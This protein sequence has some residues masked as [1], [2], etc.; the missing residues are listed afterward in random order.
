LINFKKKKFAIII[1]AFNEEKNIFKLTN[2]LL[3]LFNNAII[4]IIDDSPKSLKKFFK[5]KKIIY[6]NRKNKRGRGSAV[7]YGLRQ[8]LKLKNIKLFVEMDADFSHRPNELNKNLNYFLANNLDL[9]VSSRYLKASKIVNWPISRRFF[10]F[11]AN[12]LA[13]FFL[14][15]NISDY[16]NGFRIYSKRSSKIVVQKCGKIGDGFIVLSEIL[17]ILK[18]YNMKINEVSSIFINRVRGE[19]SLNFK[20]IYNSL[21]GLLK[22]Y[23][24][25]K[26]TLKRI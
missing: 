4:F 21:I 18:F 3:A 14:R 7:I 24:K 13:E 11:L 23:I 8:A 22:L 5:N 2:K 10:S 15:L 9:L 17:L 1:P 20:L 12:L 25:K 26:S 6:I 19:S 16:T